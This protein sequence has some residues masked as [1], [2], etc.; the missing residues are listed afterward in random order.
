MPPTASN[1]QLFS[2]RIASDV[3]IEPFAYVFGDQWAAVFGA[4]H[5]VVVEGR[6]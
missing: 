2:S 5:D 3:F 4:E 1:L 6:E